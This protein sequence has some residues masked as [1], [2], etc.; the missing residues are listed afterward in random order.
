M[1]QESN[2][3]YKGLVFGS[4]LGGIAGVLLAPEEG[5]KTRKKLSQK[6]EL[7]KKDYGP[8]IT[9]LSQKAG[10]DF[11]PMAEAIKQKTAVVQ[12]EVEKKVEPVVKV[13]EKEVQEAVKELKEVVAKVEKEAEVVTQKAAAIK[14]TITKPPTRRKSPR[15]FKGAKK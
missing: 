4:I 12:K 11:A 9:E 15:F 8:L 5:E 6:L 13:A 3:F 7:I 2:S 14:P 1:S 10:H